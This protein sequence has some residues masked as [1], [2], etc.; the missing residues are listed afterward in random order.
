MNPAVIGLVCLL[1]GL[2]IGGAW[3]YLGGS[4]G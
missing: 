1:M 2:V 3:G 4:H